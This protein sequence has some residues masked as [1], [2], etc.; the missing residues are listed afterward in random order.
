MHACNLEVVFGLEFVSIEFKFD[1]FGLAPSD[2]LNEANIEYAYTN[3]RI[4]FFLTELWTLKAFSPDC[5]NCMFCYRTT[6]NLFL[7]PQ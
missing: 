5:P 6:V 1:E 2:S 4:E 7:S 3:P